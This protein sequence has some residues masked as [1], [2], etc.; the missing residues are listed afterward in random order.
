MLLLLLYQACKLNSNKIH[1]T[2]VE[3]HGLS[4]PWPLN[5]W[6]LD[7]IGPI[8]LPGRGRVWILA[9]TEYYTKWVDLIYLKQASGA[10][11][12]NF[13]REKIICRFGI[14]NCLL[15]DS[16]TRS[17]N[18]HVWKLLADYKSELAKSSSYYPY[19]NE[20][21]KSSSYYP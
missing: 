5:I 9:T 14:P 15:S 20:L 8:N 11:M 10:S 18:M 12:T 13:I 19:K 6:A 1:A 16:G 4:T 21:A 7:L 2:S 3:L 17:F